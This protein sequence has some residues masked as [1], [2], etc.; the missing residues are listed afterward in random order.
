[1]DQIKIGEFIARKRKEQELTQ[2]QF[3][4]LAG[5]SNK[6]V[7]K[8]ETGARMP[9]VA[10]LQDVCDVLKITVNEFLA[11]EEFTEKE[12]RQRSEDNV[13]GL[14]QELN[15]IKETRRS[16]FLGILCSVLVLVCAMILT[17]I[18]SVDIMN[19]PFFFN[20]P[21]I[22]Y[23]AGLF[24]FMLGVTGAFPKYIAGYKCWLK[25]KK[26]SENEIN[27]IICTLEYAKKLT[28][29]IGFFVFLVNFVAVCIHYE[30]TESIGPFL[31]AGVLS[32][33]YMIFIEVIH[34]QIW[35]KCKLEMLGE[36][37]EKI[38]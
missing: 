22:F 1:M 35:Y 15:E 32:L 23:M 26:Y 11:G 29:L 31:S 27:K 2:M 25:V 6:T 7:S 33:F 28:R 3:A 17:M 34:D 21:A 38:F 37:D 5:V 36:K 18:S 4:E 30:H 24:L 10:I 19:I 13:I 14:V 12:Y 16:G 9:D 8:W 20:A